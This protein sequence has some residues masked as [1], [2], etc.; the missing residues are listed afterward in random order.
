MYR[1]RRHRWHYLT[2]D[3]LHR[4][5]VSTVTNYS[6]T[7]VYG[8]TSNKP[9][10]IPSILGKLT[11]L[12][13]LQLSTNQLTGESEDIFQSHQILRILVF[14]LRSG[15]TRVNATPVG[16]RGRLSLLRN[17]DSTV[18]RVLSCSFCCCVLRKGRSL[19]EEN[20]GPAVGRQM[21][22]IPFRHKCTLH[23]ASFFKPRSVCRRVIPPPLPG[24][25]ALE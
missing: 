20:V 4:H 13:V 10:L 9:G 11:K 23:I 22:V 21:Q 25:C 6:L 8:A 7:H 5:E 12:T 24:Q 15:S 2:Y 14:L 18:A 3:Y 17:R 19:I 1:D 16:R